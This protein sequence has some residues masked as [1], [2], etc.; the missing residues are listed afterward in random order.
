MYR[1]PDDVKLDFKHSSYKRIGKFLE[2]LC[3][4]EFIHYDEKKFKGHKLVTKICR[5][6]EELVNYVPCCSLKKGKIV[7]QDVVHQDVD[8]NSGDL[9]LYPKVQIDQVY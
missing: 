7:K 4:V 9:K 1:G 2:H 5:D 8:E 6:N 3:K